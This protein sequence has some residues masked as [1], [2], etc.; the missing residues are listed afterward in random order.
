MHLLLTDETNLPSDKN[1]KFFVYGGLLFPVDALVPIHD[2][3]AQIRRKAGYKPADELKFETNAKPKHVSIEACRNAKEQVVDLCVTNG[4]KFIAC[5]TLHAI[6]KGVSQEEMVRRG[7]NHV[8]G[9]FNWYLSE[10]HDYG[11]CAV[12]RLPAKAEY[13]YLTDKF[14]VGLD[15]DKG[16]RVS[17]DRVK[18]FASTCVNASHAASAMDIVLGSFRYCINQPQ[19]IESAKRMMVNVTRMVWHTR[20]GES[21]YALEKGLM[22][23]PK[24]VTVASYRQEYD[25]LLD[26]INSLIKD[27]DDL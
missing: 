21:I 4:C 17:L 6:A 1:A 8:I 25:K 14:T 7:A 11:I 13:K 9:R 16:G 23:R 19:N 24:T 20:K 26:H 22:F 27:A 3:I 10:H 5:V 12:D 2:G 15:L 18:L